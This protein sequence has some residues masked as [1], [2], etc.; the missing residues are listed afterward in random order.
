MAV[1]LHQGVPGSG[2][3]VYL[4]QQNIIPTLRNTKSEIYTN[5]ESLSPEKLGIHFDIDPLECSS[6]IKLVDFYDTE[7]IR[8]FPQWLPI[9]AT[10]ILDEAQNYFGN[11]DWNTQFAKEMK[12]YITRHRH[13]GH[14]IIIATPDID[15]LDISIRKIAHLTYDHRGFSLIGQGKIVS[16][17]I[18][19]GADLQ[20]Q[21][22][23]KNKWKHNPLVYQCY[24]SYISKEVVEKKVT[25]NVFNDLKLKLLLVGILI[26]AGCSIRS[27]MFGE[28]NY[29]G[30]DKKSIQKAKQVKEPLQN[31]NTDKKITSYIQIGDSI[32]YKLPNGETVK[33]PKGLYAK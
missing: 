26:F 31:Q 33:G 24:D 7:K 32:I 21:P 12:S 16:Y 13:Q 29:L 9:N 6:R 18:F 11:L 20:N 3:T 14:N 15:M 28:K 23:E 10:F 27:F 4:I 25:I 8:S 2:K 19:Y 22:K 17:A 1:I 30:M 5:I